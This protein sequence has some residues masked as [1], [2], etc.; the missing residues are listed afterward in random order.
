MESLLLQYYSKRKG[1]REKVQE[2]RC[3]RK[4]AGEKVQ[5]AVR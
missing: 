5:E 4:G 3:R 2:K 1:A